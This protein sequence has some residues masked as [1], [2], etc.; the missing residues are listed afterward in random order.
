MR[1]A[2]PPFPASSLP[3][4]PSSPA[5]TARVFPTPLLAAAGHW[6]RPDWPSATCGSCCWA[7][8]GRGAAVVMG[9]GRAGRGGAG[10]GRCGSISRSIPAW[11]PAGFPLPAA[12]EIARA[13]VLTSRL[14]LRSVTGRGA[15]VRS[16]CLEGLPQGGHVG[17]CQAGGGCSGPGWAY[18][19]C[20]VLL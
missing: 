17:L 13:G 3:H 18:V 14:Y 5:P 2:C 19:W 15:S 11:A 12:E 8:A 7:R 16:P 6:S 4:F 9:G 1:T 10:V 20:G